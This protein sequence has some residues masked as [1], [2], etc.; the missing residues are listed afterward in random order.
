[1]KPRR[2]RPLESS[3][4]PP[5]LPAISVFGIAVEFTAAL[6][7]ALAVG[8]STVRVRGLDITDSSFAQPT[9]VSGRGLRLS[10]RVYDGS[11]YPKFPSRTHFAAMFFPASH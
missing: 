5:A 7:L 10:G 11:R 6:S 4:I 8:S 3:G 2:V 1:M 9:S